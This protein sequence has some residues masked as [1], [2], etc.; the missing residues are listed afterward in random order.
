MSGVALAAAA[1][2]LFGVFQ[3]FNR[4]ANQLIDAYRGTFVL[5]AVSAVLLGL[6]ASLTQDLSLLTEAPPVAFLAFFTAGMIQFFVAWTFLGLSQQRDGAARTGVVIA[7]SPL[8]ATVL[9]S[10]VLDEPLPLVTAAGVV[11]TV[12]GVA[13]M[14]LTRGRGMKLHAVPWFALVSAICWGISPLFIRFGLDELP[15]PLIG[16]TIGLAG[17][18][19]L[20]GFALLLRR[21]SA[22]PGKGAAVWLIAAAIVVAAAITSQ[23]TSFGLIEIS[24]A[25]TLLQ[26]ATPTVVLVAPIIVRTEAERP[27]V[28]LVAGMVAILA[29]SLIV[30]WG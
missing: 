1:G 25:V 9:A 11:L 26:L 15:S 19:T 7:A 27:S 6:I 20:Y 3:A 17:A 4:R 14:S 30:I 8:I 18:A 12:V 23:W 16:V 2:L 5:I 10:I 24:V 22:P 28:A 29:G 13:L 21:P